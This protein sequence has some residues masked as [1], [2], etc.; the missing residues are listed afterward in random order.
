M[1]E[2]KVD[3]GI[4]SYPIYISPG[5]IGYLGEWLSQ[6][7]FS[8]RTLVVS[9]TTVG[10]LYG[11]TVVASLQANGFAAE[12]VCVAAGEASKCLTAAEKIYTQAILAGLDRKSTI[13]ALGGGVVGDLAGFAAATYL[14]GVPFIQVPTTLLAQVDSSVGGKVAVDH[15]LGKNLIGA[16]YQPKLVVIDPA[17]LETLPDRE[18]K[19]GLAEVVKHGVI[20]DN[21]FFAFLNDNSPAILAKDP[22]VLSR[23]I[24]RNCEI[25]ASVVEQDEREANLR[26]ILNFGHT[27]GHAIEAGA[28][29]ERYRHGEAIAIGMHGAALLSRYLGLCREDTVLALKNTL[30]RFG[31]PVQSSE[32]RAEQL[33]SFIERDKKNISGSINWVLLEDIGR[34]TIRSDVPADLVK[35]VLTEITGI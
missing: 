29:F 19:A 1:E 34:V 31:L 24:R 5:S 15:I 23:I 20:A 28:G 27:I 7:D 17:V 16:F 22:A 4:H 12:L 26:M 32:C 13:I 10:P 9:D 3:L 6:A 14:R 11:E 33:L 21:D 8:T 25:K 35:R 30:L 18:L 2:V